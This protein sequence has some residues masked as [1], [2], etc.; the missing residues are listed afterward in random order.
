MAFSHYFIYKLLRASL[1]VIS[2][3][4]L[5]INNTLKRIWLNY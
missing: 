3:K 4:G 5:Y 1:K 2:L